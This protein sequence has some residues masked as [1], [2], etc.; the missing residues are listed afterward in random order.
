MREVYEGSLPSEHEMTEL[1]EEL[2]RTTEGPT[3]S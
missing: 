3:V 2:R 1:P